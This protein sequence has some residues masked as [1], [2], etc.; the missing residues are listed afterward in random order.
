VRLED[1]ATPPCVVSMLEDPNL[2][3]RAKADVRRTDTILRGHLSQVLGG[4]YKYNL[5]GT[6]THRKPRKSAMTKLK[7]QR[8]IQGD[9]P[10]IRNEILVSLQR[11]T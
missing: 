7:I 5:D 1:L 11:T 8:I 6:V 2:D 3:E 4:V 9:S 10:E